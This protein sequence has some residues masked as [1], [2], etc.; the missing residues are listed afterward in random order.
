MATD[1]YKE[2]N[3]TG[4]ALIKAIGGLVQIAR[5]HADNNDLLL[6]AAEKIVGLITQVDAEEDSVTLVHSDGRFYFQGKRLHIRPESK[7]IINRMQQYLEKRGI[8]S[9]QFKPAPKEVSGNQ[10]IT[11]ARLID[12]AGQHAEPTEWLKIQFEKRGIKWVDFNV[13]TIDQPNAPCSQSDD[14]PD[15]QAFKRGQARKQYSQVLGSI[16]EVSRKLSSNQNV[17]MRNSIRLVQKM[18]DIITEDESLFSILGTLRLYDDYTYVHSLNVAILSMCM[19]KQIGLDHIMLERLGLCGLFHDLGKVEIPKTILN[20]RSRLSDAE[21]DEIKTHPVH[22]ARLILKLKARQD[23]KVKILV[24]PFEHHMAYN[25]SGYPQS[26]KDW[27]VSLFGRILAIADVYDAITSPRIYRTQILS[28]DKAL[29]QMLEQSG[30][31]FD[32]ILL[33]VFINMLGA[34][35][36]GTLLKLDTGEMGIVVG[37]SKSKD[38]TYPIVQLLIADAEKK[39][40]KGALVDLSDQHLKGGAKQRK[41]IESMHPSDMG[42]QAAEFLLQS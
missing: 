6:E 33:K 37:R 3:Q 35:P 5:M 9:L 23:R 12:Q 26:R 32:P 28:P 31:S 34:Y 16:K 42:I 39:F 7:R 40:K 19:G 17:G 41:I 24:A 29:G 4:E 21:F 15:E 8:F 22:S 20:K 25:R 18:V 11:F 38:G 2:I 36:V 30:A 10:T 27:N 13:E 14:E 1:Y